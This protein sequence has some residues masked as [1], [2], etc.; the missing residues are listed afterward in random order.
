MKDDQAIEVALA[1][2]PLLFANE[3]EALQEWINEMPARVRFAFTANLKYPSI[4]GSYGELLEHP[5]SKDTKYLEHATSA[6]LLYPV[7]AH[8]AATL[9]DDAVFATVDQLQSDSFS[10]AIFS[11]GSQTM[12]QR[13][14]F[15]KT[16]ISMGSPSATFL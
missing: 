4:L 15:M 2:I 10:T 16:R 8:I 7:L 12:R 11:S 6:S 1:A 3:D 14:T 5:A 9:E 13:I